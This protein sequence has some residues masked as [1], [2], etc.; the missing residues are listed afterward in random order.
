MAVYFTFVKPGDTLM[1]MNLSHGGHLTHGSPVNFSGQFYRFVPY[2]VNPATGMIDFNEVEDLAKKE[3]PKMITVGAS[4]YSRNIDYKA[5]RDDRRQGRRIPL[6]GYCA[7]GRTHRAEAAERSDPPL[8]RGD[9]HD[10][11]DPARSAWRV[12][13]ARARTSTIRSDSLRR[14]RAA[15]SGCRSCSTRWSSPAFRAVRSCTSLPARPLHSAKRSSPSFETYARQV[16]SNAQT[17]AAALIAR[18]YNIVSGGTDNH[19]M[20]IDLR[21]KNIN[22]Q[23]S[24]GSAR[25]LGHHRQQ[26]R[27]PVRRQESAHH[28]RHPDRHTGPDHT[29]HA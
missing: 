4:A 1:G 5:F 24:A 18:G 25:H 3:R 13:P 15:R 21:N 29:R 10:A 11:Q 27:R 6:R 26:E 17:L 20:L 9:I 22:G 19:L 8:P 28:Q 2:G 7:S 23:R 14:N 12:D 16:I